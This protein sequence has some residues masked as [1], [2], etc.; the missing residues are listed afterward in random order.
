M[1]GLILAFMRSLNT[2]GR[3]RA[4]AFLLAP[5]G[6]ALVAWA[7]LTY[8]GLERLT[9][10]FLELPPMNW[11][12]SWG[13]NGLAGF[14]ARVGA[15]LTLLALAYFLAIALAGA[16][17]LPWQMAWLARAEYPQVAPLGRA[18]LIGSTANSLWAGSLFLCGWLV[19]LPLWLIPGL[20]LILPVLWTAWLYRR[21]FAYEALSAHATREEWRRIR[22]E[23]SQPLLIIGLALAI[24]SPIPLVGLLAPGFGAFVY[25]HFALGAL[26]RLR[27]G[28]ADSPGFGPAV[29]NGEAILI[30]P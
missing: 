28:S 15:W 10:L 1:S 14:M 13:W 8:F 18:S 19:T 7:L 22:Q 3:G 27:A 25:G 12:A 16:W 29:I 9:T 17:I 11:V 2:L 6:I 30:D 26:A 21:T 20:G 23:H 5:A 24:L 4:W